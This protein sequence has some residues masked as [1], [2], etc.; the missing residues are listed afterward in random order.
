MLLIQVFILITP[1]GSVGIE[2]TTEGLL[3]RSLRSEWSCGVAIIRVSQ[4]PM[5]GGVGLVR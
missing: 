1:V 3:G 5:S 2:P 4:Q